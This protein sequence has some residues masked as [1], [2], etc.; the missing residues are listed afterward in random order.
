VIG[1]DFKGGLQ[2]GQVLLA[3]VLHHRG[4]YTFR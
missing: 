4:D 3:H 1:V 2:L